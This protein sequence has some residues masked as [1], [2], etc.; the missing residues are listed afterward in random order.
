M[1]FGSF[2]DKAKKAAQEAARKAQIEA[3]RLADEHKDVIESAKE[4]LSDTQKSFEDV[5]SATKKKADETVRDVNMKV[6]E[7]ISNAKDN[8]DELNEQLKSGFDDVMAQ[9]KQQSQA[10]ANQAIKKTSDVTGLSEDEINARLDAAG[11]AMTSA[12]AKTADAVGTAASVTGEYAVKAGKTI[13]G[14]QAYQDRK[15]SIRL[16]DETTAL[17]EEI[18]KGN[19][20]KRSE[21]NEA[22]VAF[23]RCRTEA[24]HDVVGR[25][26]RILDT[27]GRKNKAK[28]YEMLGIADI[29]MDKIG[30]MEQLD[31][32]ASEALKTLGVAG[33]F[34]GVALAGTPALVTGAVGA[35]ATASTG[36]AISSLS[37]V[38]ASNAILAWLG[39]GSIAAGGG[40]VAAGAT[41]LAGITYAA[42]GVFAVA[43]AGI[44]ATAFYSKK[45]TEATEEKAKVEKWAAE[46]KQ[47]WVIMDGI[48]RRTQELHSLTKDLLTRSDAVLDDL[49]MIA[50]S[51]NANDMEHVKKFQQ[52][53]LLVKSMTELAQT[54]LLDDDG[55]VSQAAINIQPRLETILNNDLK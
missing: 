41:V 40:G 42:T 39:G 52:A 9:A 14:V 24:L 26:L 28:E 31:M 47:G 35:L 44:V 1:A 51:F 29:S 19:E 45:L 49:E 6:S 15:E 48:K 12:A 46:V 38:A 33:G 53:A 25:F 30:Q 32:G 36:T 2:I 17:I 10:L 21:L 20:Q 43:A 13:S 34:A 4:T 18:E 55:N 8:V 23:G 50:P 22:L 37:G 7:S 3:Q 27:M 16:H 54:P 5:V 11:A